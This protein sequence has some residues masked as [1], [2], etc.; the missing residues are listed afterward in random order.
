MELLPVEEEGR[1][2]DAVLRENFVERVFAYSR[3]QKFL[4]EDPTPAGLVAFHTRHKLT[5]LSH[6]PGRYRELERRVARAG[7]GSWPERQA[8][9]ARGFMAA[10]QIHA[11]RGLHVMSC[12]TS[13]VFC[14]GTWM[15]GTG[16]NWWRSSRIPARDWCRSSSRSP[17]FATMY[18]AA[19]ARTGCAG[20][21]T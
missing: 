20:R 15:E 12:S 17:Y 19:P 10:L 21:S 1:L 5:L 4:Q 9:Y 3:W 2:R 11:T 14:A 7:C 13:W 8:E 6:H 18:A 16:K